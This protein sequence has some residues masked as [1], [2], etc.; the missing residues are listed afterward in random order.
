MDTT[1]VHITNQVS[2]LLQ[3]LAA[4]MGV[5]VKALW[6]LLV[7]LE[8][9]RGLT[10]SIASLLVM[11]L[12]LYMTKT[13]VWDDKNMDEGDKAGITFACLVPISA[14]FIWFMCSLPSVFC[15]A[16]VALQHPISKLR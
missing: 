8:F 1:W 16:G 14:M 10:S 7:Q 2:S 12:F 4:G 11:F 13:Y 15:P 9:A 5:A 6:P 3:S